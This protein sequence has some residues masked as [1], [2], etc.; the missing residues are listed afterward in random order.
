[1]GCIYVITNQAN[2]KKYV[3]QTTKTADVRFKEHIREAR[4]NGSGS[5]YLN[6]AITKY[7][8]DNF[9]VEVLIDNIDSA[10]ELDSLETYHI[11]SLDTL[12]PTGYNIQTGGQ[13]KGRRH[14]DESRELM[15][16]KK[17]GESNHNYGKPRTDAAKANIS[18]AKAGE[19]H[20]FYGKT[21]SDNHKTKLSK[22][23]KKYDD[24]LPMYI[25]YVAPRE[26]YPNTGYVVINPLTN[27][28]TYFT[29]LKLTMD[30]KLQKANDLL[31]SLNL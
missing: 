21:L 7:G 12:A 28:R 19:K 9:S 26:R 11:K 20:H 16:Q 30:E 24:S 31:E 25:G 15:R 1:M 23:H 2:G 29:S 13:A 14:C 3:G 5:R 8:E 6:N 22:S 27:K 10:E 17:L 4:Y 18:K